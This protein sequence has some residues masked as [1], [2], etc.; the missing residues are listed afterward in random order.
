MFFLLDKH[1]YPTAA[2]N[3]ILGLIEARKSNNAD[4]PK[5]FTDMIRWYLAIQNTLLNLMSWLFKV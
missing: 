1:L 5:C 3:N 4:D 2:L